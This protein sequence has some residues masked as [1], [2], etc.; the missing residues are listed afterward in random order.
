[1]QHPRQQLSSSGSTIVTTVGEPNKGWF[2]TL[3][4]EGGAWY[5]GIIG[6]WYVGPGVGAYGTWGW[7]LTGLWN[8]GSGVWYC[9][10]WTPT[11]AGLFKAGFWFGSQT[12]FC[13]TMD[14]T[15]SGVKRNEKLFLKPHE[16]VWTRTQIEGLRSW[17]Y[18]KCVYLCVGCV[19]FFV[20]RGTRFSLSRVQPIREVC[21]SGVHHANGGG[22][23]SMS[24]PRTAVL[25]Q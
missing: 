24:L 22:G 7:G 10:G 2:S 8:E 19:V 17:K 4:F 3:T 16:K 14:E 5:V 12:L 18:K 23:I 15:R 6:G 21:L 9:G 11:C 25:L 1:M 20:S 13:I